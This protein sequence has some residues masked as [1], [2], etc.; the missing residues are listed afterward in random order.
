VLNM[1]DTIITVEGQ[2]DHHHP[3]ERGTVHVVVGFEGPA[4]PTV[5]D[6]TTALHAWLAQQARQLVTDGAVTWWSAD[7]MRMWSDR[8]WNKDGLQ[9]ALVHHAAV[10]LEVKFAQLATLAEW[11]ETIAALDGVTVSG[12]SWAL[13]EV[14]KARITLDAQTRAVQDALARAT[15]YASSLGLETLHP[16]AV[17]DPGMLGDQSRPDIASAA[18][19]MSR[20]LASQPTDAPLD[21][22]P[23]D[24]TITARVHARFAAS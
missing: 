11:V 4:R 13:T 22:K 24:I 16:L 19:L 1:S 15:A 5:V 18:P 6:Q 8:P 20:A 9:L 10:G 7:R 3:A 2:F 21:L 12:V 23:E 17:A 14:T